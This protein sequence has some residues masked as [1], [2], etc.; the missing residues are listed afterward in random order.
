MHSAQKDI[1]L[2]NDKLQFLHEKQMKWWKKYSIFES[3][4]A[5]DLQDKTDSL[6]LST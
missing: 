3:G 5:T 1:Y 4:L 6:R 2:V